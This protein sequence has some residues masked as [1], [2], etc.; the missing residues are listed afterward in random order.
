MSRF[1]RPIFRFHVFFWLVW[2]PAAG[3]ATA[4]GDGGDDPL[5][6]AAPRPDAFVP[7]GSDAMPDAVVVDAPPQCT[8]MDVQLLGNPDFD[9]GP[10]GGWEE[11]AADPIVFDSGTLPVTPHSGDYAAWLGGVNGATRTLYQDV[12]IPAG[13]TNIRLSLYRRIA[14][15]ELGGGVY[16]TFSLTLRN[17]SNAVLE[18]VVDWN[19]GDTVGTWTVFDHV[20]TGEY[21][22]QTVRVHL[23][24]TN[25]NSYNTNFF[26]DSLALQATVCL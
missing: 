19:N 11:N 23:T 14:T 26:I 13:A 16:D 3:C 6:D 25:D 17:T 8:D 10:G 12:S 20:A 9:L 24:S 21:G 15:E 18:N 1:Q 4:G 2:L 5:P 7:P 22:G